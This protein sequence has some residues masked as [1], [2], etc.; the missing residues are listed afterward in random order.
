MR[1]GVSSMKTDVIHNNKS[2]YLNNTSNH[3][4][5]Y[6][7]LTTSHKALNKKNAEVAPGS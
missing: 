5:N 3:T 6:S 2:L 7:A 4:S 1:S